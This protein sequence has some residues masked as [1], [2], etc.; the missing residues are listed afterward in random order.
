[1]SCDQQTFSQVSQSAFDCLKQKALAI[2]ITIDS[3][4]GQ[5]SKNGITVAWKFDPD[6]QTLELV[7]TEKPFII[8]CGTIN[9]KI[10]E[11]VDQCLQ[12]LSA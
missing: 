2:G 7:C 8:P 5:S 6:T 10:R 4:Q 9:S 3:D 11:V 12:Q 1:M